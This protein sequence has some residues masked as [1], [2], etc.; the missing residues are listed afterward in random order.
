MTSKKLETLWFRPDLHWERSRLAWHRAA[1]FEAP[2]NERKP[3][4]PD[5]GERAYHETT[6]SERS[7]GRAWCV[8]GPFTRLRYRPFHGPAMDSVCLRL[9]VCSLSGYSGACRV[10]VNPR[11]T[12]G[13]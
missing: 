10:G 7:L 5:R 4:R 6:S 2:L 12:Q 9:A 8:L 13:G 3:P 11:R 1:P